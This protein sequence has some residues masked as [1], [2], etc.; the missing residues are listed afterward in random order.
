MMAKVGL[1]S[2][3]CPKNVVDAEEI[4]WEV[5]RAGHEIV[6][7]PAEAEALI[8]NT[9]GFI[10]SAK[11][12]SIEAILDAVRRKTDSVCR[13]VVVTGCLVER[14]GA[15]LIDELPE[16]DAFVG[17]GRAGDI[18]AVLAGSLSPETGRNPGWWIKSKGRVLSTPPW[19][20]FLRVADGCDNRCSY[21]AI[22]S[23]RGGFRS[24]RER[25]VLDEAKALAD[26]GVLEINL[27]AQDTTR[28]GEDLGGGESLARLLDRLSDIEGLRWIRVLYCYPTRIS[29]ELIRVFASG[30]KVCKYVDVP[31]QHSS[32]P[33]LRAMGRKGSGDEYLKLFERIRSACPDVAL[34]TTFLVGFPGETEEDF[35]SLLGFVERARFDRVGVF[36]FSPEDGTAAAGMKGRVPKRTADR[37]ARELLALQKGISLEKNRGLIGRNLDV[38]V[39]SSGK[40]RSYR[41]APEIDGFV[42]IRGGGVRPGSIVKVEIVDA[43]AHDLTA[44]LIKD[45]VI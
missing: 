21:C 38:L 3:G 5:E 45:Q 36:T 43:R 29:T 2:L 7:D 24:R 14:Y 13:F 31:L 34:R 37:R 42:S 32:E 25:D 30:D 18:P 16:V 44:C 1:V 33:V 41:D 4:L 40:G 11:E 17:L 10:Q 8:I 28:Y 35:A 20:A 22:P 15:E 23:I 39:E 6:S 26:S 27:V 19:T 9:C 12:E